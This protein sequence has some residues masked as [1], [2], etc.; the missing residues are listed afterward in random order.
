MTPEAPPDRHPWARPLIA[1]AAV[2]GIVALAVAMLTWLSSGALSGMPAADSRTSP[3]TVQASTEDSGA[4]SEESATTPDADESDATRSIVQG[5]TLE[6]SGDTAFVVSSFNVLGNNHT[7]NGARGRQ[8][9]TTRIRWAADLLESQQVSV[10][11]LQEFQAPQLKAFRRAAPHYAM[12]PGA[13]LGHRLT[14]NSIIW[15]K[16][17][18]SRERVGTTPIPY[19]RGTLVPMPHVLLRHRITGQ[20]VWFMNYHNP[21]Q[22][23]GPAGQWRREATSIEADLAN[24]LMASAPVVMTGDFN[25]REEFFCQIS[26]EAALHSS[27]GGYRSDGECRPPA[28]PVV[29]WILGSPKVAF[30]DATIDRRARVKKISDHAM[31]RATAT[32]TGTDDSTDVPAD[33]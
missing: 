29:D 4:A 10:A 33:D 9:G 32:I 15:D 23:N 21:A 18:W 13:S 26:R 25:A 3:A 1:V 2:T 12:Y 16:N 6:P 27:D 11:G 17:V 19:F 30:T 24:E 20:Q 31:I 5:S 7:L 14:Q 28:E 8:P 22:V